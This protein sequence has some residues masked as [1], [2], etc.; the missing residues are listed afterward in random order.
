[1][2]LVLFDFDQAKRAGPPWVLSPQGVGELFG[3]AGYEVRS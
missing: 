2:L 1:M 3:D